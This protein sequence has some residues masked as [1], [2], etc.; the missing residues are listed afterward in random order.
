MN[1]VDLSGCAA[2]QRAA[3]ESWMNNY[4]ASLRK[5]TWRDIV[6]N[7]PDRFKIERGYVWERDLNSPCNGWRAIHPL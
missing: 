6:R 7:N 5:N 1:R 4:R 3:H 2:R